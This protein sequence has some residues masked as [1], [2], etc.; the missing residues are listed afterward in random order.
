MNLREGTRRLALL[1]GA[2]GAI[3]GGFVSY[4]EL[5]TVLSQRAQHNKFDQLANSDVVQQE[6]KNLQAEPNDWQTIP[7]DKWAKYA[8]KSKNIPQIDPKTGERI[9]I[10]PQTG[11]RITALPP[12]SKP[13][14]PWE[15][16]AP[17][18]SNVKW[19]IRDP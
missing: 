14:Q 11:E 6:R 9:Q 17:L 18:P 19:E 15:K 5:Q 3:L 10:D 12:C 8:V 4:F 7:N 2:I 1:L 16:C 13:H